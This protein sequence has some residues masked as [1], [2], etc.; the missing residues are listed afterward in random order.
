MGPLMKKCLLSSGI[1]LP[2]SM[3]SAGTGHSTCVVAFGTALNSLTV[4]LHTFG[5]GALVL[6]GRPGA[7]APHCLGSAIQCD[8]HGDRGTWLYGVGAGRVSGIRVSMPYCQ[9]VV[10]RCSIAKPD[11]SR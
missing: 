1:R 11:V 6:K 3:L 9:M 10:T 7:P 8:K 4:V 5:A 2:W